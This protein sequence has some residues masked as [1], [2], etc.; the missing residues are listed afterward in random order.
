MNII[1]FKIYRDGRIRD[2]YEAYI[3]DEEQHSADR[4][5]KE[6]WLRLRR[7]WMNHADTVLAYAKEEDVSGLMDCWRIIIKEE[8]FS[9]EH[10]GIG[11]NVGLTSENISEIIAVSENVRNMYW[12]TSYLKNHPNYKENLHHSIMMNVHE[13]HAKGLAKNDRF[14]DNE[15][16]NLHL[17]GRMLGQTRRFATSQLNKAEKNHLFEMLDAAHNIPASLINP[18]DYS[19]EDDIVRLKELLDDMDNKRFID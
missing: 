1:E 19:I 9:T 5:V 10:E 8:R 17:L 7:M 11:L 3:D 12:I 6:S 4:Y 16:N 15:I 2:L 14:T 18:D 13:T